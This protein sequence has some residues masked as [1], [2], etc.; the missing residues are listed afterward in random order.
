MNPDKPTARGRENDSRRPH[1]ESV[2]MSFIIGIVRKQIG[3]VAD[4]PSRQFRSFGADAV[5]PIETSL[6]RA[7]WAPLSQILAAW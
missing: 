1:D 3:A 2:P 7:S 4:A 5:R 6:R